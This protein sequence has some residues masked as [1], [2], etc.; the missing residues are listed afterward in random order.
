M[1]VPGFSNSLKPEPR[2]SLFNSCHLVGLI[3][4]CIP[5]WQNARSRENINQTRCIVHLRLLLRTVP[6]LR[7]VK[8]RSFLG[9]VLFFSFCARNDRDHHRRFGLIDSSSFAMILYLLLGNHPF[10]LASHSQNNHRISLLV[11]FQLGFDL[12]GYGL[13]KTG[14]VLT[15]SGVSD[16]RL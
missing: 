4:G 1:P 6:L 2:E 14:F 9:S 10:Y 5:T 8:R 11:Q 13:M 15:R 12:S 3:L 7:T 16:R